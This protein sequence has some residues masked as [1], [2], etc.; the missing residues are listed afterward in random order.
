M[1]WVCV[2]LLTFTKLFYF[3]YVL[4]CITMKL[5]TAWWLL[6]FISYQQHLQLRLV[7]Q[8]F[9]FASIAL[10]RMQLFIVCTPSAA[11]TN[12]SVLF[13]TDNLCPS[14]CLITPATV[15]CLKFS[16][17][18]HY[19][20]LFIYFQWIGYSYLFPYLLFILI[21][22]YK[23]GTKSNEFH[24]LWASLCTVILCFCV[25]SFPSLPSSFLI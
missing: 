7:L 3:T 18:C 23:I 13:L 2:R 6:L 5:F 16:F 20:G 24:S 11:E 8:V 9:E 22:S 17:L 1:C 25:S 12:Y 15:L 14:F 19:K 10:L 21:N 4:K